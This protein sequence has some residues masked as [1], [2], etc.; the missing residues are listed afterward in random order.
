MLT[1]FCKC[2]G[3]RFIVCLTSCALKGEDSDEE[4]QL[5]ESSDEYMTKCSS[6][7]AQELVVQLPRAVFSE[8]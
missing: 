8:A 5:S 6:P 1:G 7:G 4:S 2:Y 3:T